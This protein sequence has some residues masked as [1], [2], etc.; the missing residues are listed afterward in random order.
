[1]WLLAAVSE[2]PENEEPV[3]E[4]EQATDET[5]EEAELGPGVQN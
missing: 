2:E 1:M 3:S 5:E 4:T